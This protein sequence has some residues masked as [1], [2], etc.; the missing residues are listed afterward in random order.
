MPGKLNVNSTGG[1]V[2]WEAM[3]E[4]IMRARNKNITHITEGFWQFL[5]LKHIWQI[6]RNRTWKMLNKDK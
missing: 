2:K 5:S 3:I 1:W 6:C 4:F